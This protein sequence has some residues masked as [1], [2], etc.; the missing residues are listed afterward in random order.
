MQWNPS[1]GPAGIVVPYTSV[2]IP[3]ICVH[4][5][6]VY[7]AFLDEPLWTHPVVQTRVEIS[8]LTVLIE[9]NLISILLFSSYFFSFFYSILAHFCLRGS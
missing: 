5:R 2:W 9:Q 3:D 4:N 1:D 8:I 7:F 6:P